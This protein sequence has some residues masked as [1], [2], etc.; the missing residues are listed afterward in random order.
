MQ[1]PAEV[2]APC[3]AQVTFVGRE[4]SAPTVAV[5]ARIGSSLLEAARAAGLEVAATCGGRGRCCSCRV[6][7]LKGNV[8]PASVQDRIQLGSEGVRERFRLSCQTPVIGDCSVLVAPPRSEAGHRILATGVPT[9]SDPRAILDSGVEKHVIE[10]GARAATDGKT[11]DAEAILAH[12]GDRCAG[13]FPLE[14]LRKI[15]GALRA[16]GARVTITTFNGEAIAIEPGDTSARKFGMAFDIGTT[17]LVATLLDLAT[18]EHLATVSDLNPQA[19]Y[20][21]DVMSRIAFAQFDEKKLATLRS[22]VLNAVNELIDEACAA[23]NVSGETIYKAV[24]VGNTCMHHLLLGIDTSDLG[25]APYTPV[26]RAPMVMAARELPLKAAPNARICF[27]PIVAGFVGADTVAAALATGIHESEE[28]R[29]LVDIGT[30]GEVVLGSKRRLLA[31]SAPAGPAFE[32]GQIKHG[33]RAALGAIE[34]VDFGDDVACRIIGDVPAIGVCGSGLI[35]AVAKMLEAGLVDGGGAFVRPQGGAPAARLSERLRDTEDGPELVLVSA[36][37]AGNGEDITIAQ[38]DVRQL[39]LAKAAICSGIMILQEVAGVADDAIEE[40]MLA[41]GFGNY[42]NIASALRIRLLPPLSPE[43]IS[44]VG[45]AALTGAELALLS[46]GARHE[47]DAIAARIDHVGL[48][49]HPDFEN[50]FVA[51]LGMASPGTDA[52]ESARAVHAT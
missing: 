18:G 7:I 13:G 34:G 35:D 48:A 41:G 43:R 40:L 33:M 23:A 32:G 49:D 25:V 29:V 4:G 1:R 37:D 17:T 39:Q 11:S 52:D 36:R 42:I 26:V 6:R 38:K 46:E 47:A 44:Y 5:Q 15:P 14:V 45:N 10:V 24:I 8:A 31:C 2:A 9:R 27:L 50:L 21:G 16:C 3:L 28:V 12:L 20:G 19:V 51:A 22:R 30:N